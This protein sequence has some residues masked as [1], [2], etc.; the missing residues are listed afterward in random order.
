MVIALPFVVS[1]LGLLVYMASSSPKVMELGRVAYWVGL[2]VGVLR[3][4]HTAISLP[5]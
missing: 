4:A 1:L 5:K 2:L 3:I